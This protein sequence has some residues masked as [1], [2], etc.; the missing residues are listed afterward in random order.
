MQNLGGRRSDL[1][2]IK[3]DQ[4]PIMADARQRAWIEAK[5]KAIRTNASL[6]KNLIGW[7]KK[8]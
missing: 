5:P 6:L 3:R 8:L 4:T 7:D 1:H 2:L